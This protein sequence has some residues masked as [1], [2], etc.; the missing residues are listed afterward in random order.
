MEDA[1]ALIDNAADYA[2]DG[3]IDLAVEEYRKALRE[4]DRIEIENP[5]RAEKPE[6]ATVR[7]KRAYVDAAIDS[8][9]LAE[10]R[11]N[12]SAVA[13]T[14]TTELE[15]EYAKRKAAEREA[16]SAVRPGAINDE[17]RF[18]NE[19][20]NGNDSTPPPEGRKARLAYAIDAMRRKDYELAHST[21]R[22]LLAEKPNDAAALNIKGSIEAETGDY[23]SAEKS[24][25]TCIQSNPRSYYAYHNMARLFMASRGEDGKEVAK[26]YYERG[27]DYGGKRDLALE[28]ALGIQEAE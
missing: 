10:A 3:K 17:T 11:R 28:K 22:K 8:L 18:V 4:L 14:D 2:E 9:L 7:N 12:A 19:R 6:F 24:F 25:D 20:L 23:E 1:T 13:I 5:D 15:K 21:V 27:L 26:M 16:R